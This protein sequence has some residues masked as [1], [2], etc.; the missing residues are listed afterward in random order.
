MQGGA[1]RR[2]SKSRRRLACT[3]KAIVETSGSHRYR[4]IRRSYPGARERVAH[5]GGIF[6]DRGRGCCSGT[7]ARAA[8]RHC[9]RVEST[10]RRGT[11]SWDAGVVQGPDHADL[12][13]VQAR[14]RRIEGRCVPAARTQGS[15]ETVHAGRASRGGTRDPGGQLTEAT[16]VLV[17]RDTRRPV[18]DHY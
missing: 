18:G 8:T 1:L 7:E 12:G 4:R 10:W 5:G 15:A 17:R 11:D 14:T 6:R 16:D 3:G 13:S 2:A 9:Q